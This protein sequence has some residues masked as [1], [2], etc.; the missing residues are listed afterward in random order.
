MSNRAQKIDVCRSIFL[1]YSDSLGAHRR[2]ASKPP[3][4]LVPAQCVPKAQKLLLLCDWQLSAATRKSEISRKS[5]WL[6][7]IPA[8]FIPPWQHG[9]VSL[10]H[11]ALRHGDRP[12][13]C[14]RRARDH[15]RLTEDLRWAKQQEE[16]R[17]GEEK[18]EKE[19]HAHAEGVHTRLLCT[20]YALTM[21]S[22][23][24]HYALTIIA[25]CP[26][27]YALKYEE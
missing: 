16:G 21:H 15:R 27:Y 1:L 11:P 23:C 14:L 5:S 7:I 3:P 18:G 6:H 17:E 4:R 24:T 19:A 12:R 25:L 13:G 9:I 10:Q 8:Q 26:H 2:S 22:L 20:Y